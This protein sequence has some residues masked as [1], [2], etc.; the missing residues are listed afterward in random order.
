MPRLAPSRW[1]AGDRVRLVDP[2]GLVDKDDIWY[3]VAGTDTGVT[4]MTSMAGMLRYRTS[5][6]AIT[7]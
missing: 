2:W 1:F 7:F 4:G 5:L 3:L 6:S